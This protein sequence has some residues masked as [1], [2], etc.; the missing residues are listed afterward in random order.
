MAA[1]KDTDKMALKGIV[2]IRAL[3]GKSKLKV[4][5]GTQKTQEQL[6]LMEFLSKEPKGAKRGDPGLLG[7]LRGF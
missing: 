4:E 5:R 7:A 2:Q 1:S 3:K 6:D